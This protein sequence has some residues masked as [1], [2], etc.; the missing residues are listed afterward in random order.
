MP[1][2]VFLP[3]APQYF[4]QGDTYLKFAEGR[5]PF[6]S[7]GGGKTVIVPPRGVGLSEDQEVLT[8]QSVWCQGEKDRTTEETEN[9]FVPIDV[10]VSSV[11]RMF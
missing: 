1:T 8:R 9:I 3:C 7:M 2:A 11:V 4:L 5:E 6:I 10:A